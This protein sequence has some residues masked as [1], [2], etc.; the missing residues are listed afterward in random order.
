MN[1]SREGRNTSGVTEKQMVVGD[2]ALQILY[3]KKVTDISDNKSK[4]LI[5]E[6]QFFPWFTTCKILF[7]FQ[8]CVHQI[9][10]MGMDSMHLQEIVKGRK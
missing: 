8:E 7:L 6:I 2:T 4:E 1:V 3:T 10:V 5:W 9:M